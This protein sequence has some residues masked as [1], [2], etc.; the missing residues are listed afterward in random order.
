MQEE[1]KNIFVTKEVAKIAKEKGFGEICAGYFSVYGEC[2]SPNSNSDYEFVLDA[3]DN[4]ESYIEAPTHFQLI[5]WLITNHKIYI[6]QES[7]ERWKIAY[8]LVCGRFGQ[9]YKNTV[10]DALIFALNLVEQ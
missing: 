7:T 6:F 4:P 5:Q 3:C 2:V 1:L 8:D 10:N 9:N